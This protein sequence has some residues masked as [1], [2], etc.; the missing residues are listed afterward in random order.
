MRR[1]RPPG[2]AGDADTFHPTAHGYARLSC[3]APGQGG[4]VVNAGALELATE[5]VS[6]QR[7][8]AGA[9]M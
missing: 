8:V 4:T 5:F 3:R 9:R 2:R 6:P 7:G 1:S